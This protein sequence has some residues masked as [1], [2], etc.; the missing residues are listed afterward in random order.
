MPKTKL[1]PD[2]V[3]FILNI[4]RQG[5]VKWPGRAEVLRKCR[6]RVFVRKSL[7]GRPIYKYHWQC[8]I[9]KS[10]TKDEKQMEVDHIVE[11]GTFSGDFTDYIDR[12][13][14]FARDNLQALCTTCHLKKTMAF[15][16]ARTRWKRKS[17]S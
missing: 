6:K 16:S 2:D 15:N 4:L 11:L 3:K 14:D 13:F 12:M 10:W 8:A 1:T 17:K 5:T 7:E 9:C